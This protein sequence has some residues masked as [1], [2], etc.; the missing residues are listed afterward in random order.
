MNPRALAIGFTLLAFM[1]ART[2]HSDDVIDPNSETSA[3]EEKLLVVEP[4]LVDADSGNGMLYAAERSDVSPGNTPSYTGSQAASEPLWGTYAPGKGFTLASTEWGE[5]R[6]SAFTYARYLNQKG[7]DD[8]YTDSF[9]RD[10][11]VDIRNDVQLQK[12]TMYF[13]GWMFD[14]NFHYL[15]Y[16]WTSNS[17]QGQSAQVVVAGNLGYKFSD[18]FNLSAGIGALP[19]TR[20]TSGTFP[21]WLKVDHRTIADEFFRASYTSGIWANGKISERSRYHV[22]LGNNLSQ[23]GV[24][25]GQLDE[26]FE[27]LSTAIWWMPTTGEYGAGEGFGD[28]EQHEEVATL[29]GANFSRSRED[30]QAQPG[31]N[32]FENSQIRLSDG[33]LIFRPD[34]FDNGTA[35][36]KATYKMAAINA[37]LKYCGYSLDTEAYW[38]WIDDFDASGPLPVDELYDHGFQLQTS[39]MVVPKR[40]Q[41]YLAGSKIYGEYGDPWDIALG[42]NFFP[43]RRQEVRLTAQMLYLDESPVGYNSVPFAV[44][45][46]GLVLSFD[47]MLSF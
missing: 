10:F 37:G 20:S 15:L 12:A 21:H 29:I 26:H 16:V 13:K 22:M 11:I 43:F 42:A 14:P 24:D 45:G 9:G 44:G 18:N 30:A 36:N 23:L 46:D 34:A 28:F 19:S 1:I 4:F 39:M 25:A 7:L 3:F 31:V 6:W 38:R 47:L 5:M 40:L 8:A 32:S 17:N 2:A 41:L 27:T 35:I 33:T